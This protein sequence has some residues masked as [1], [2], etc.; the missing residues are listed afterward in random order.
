VP[1]WDRDRDKRFE[2]EFQGKPHTHTYSTI[3]YDTSRS[4]KT[5]TVGGVEVQI[6]VCRDKFKSVC[7]CGDVSTTWEGSEYTC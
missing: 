2:E 4:Q 1:F 7:E 3:K 6:T 5:E